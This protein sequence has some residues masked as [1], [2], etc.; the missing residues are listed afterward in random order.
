MLAHFTHNALGALGP[1]NEAA[2]PEEFDA[3]SL[4]PRVTG[5]GMTAAYPIVSETIRVA[6]LSA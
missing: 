5:Q 6:S 3:P 2:K 1:V 4:W